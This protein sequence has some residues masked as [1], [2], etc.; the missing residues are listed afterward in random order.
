MPSRSRP[1]AT[2]PLRFACEKTFFVSPFNPVEG[3]YRFRLDRSD[4]TLRLTIRHSR[5]GACILGASLH[6]RRR[7]LTTR[8]L[9][10]AQLAQPFGALA[11]VGGILFEALRLRM[12]GLR[13]HAPR[14]GSVDTLPRG[15]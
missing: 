9:W 7:E 1:G 5:G 12:K 6:A 14:H 8:S 15:S 11:T 4:E 3:A 13:T 10:A 2:G